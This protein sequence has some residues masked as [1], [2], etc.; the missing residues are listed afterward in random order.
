MGIRT[1]EPRICT[2]AT[3]IHRFQSGLFRRS[4]AN[5]RFILC[6]FLLICL[7]ENA[8][9]QDEPETRDELWPEVNLYVT[10]DPKWRLFFLASVYR[11]RETDVDRE[12][13]V[14]AHVDYLYKKHLVFRAGYRYGFSPTEGS[15]YQ[16]NRILFEQTVRTYIPWKV[17]LSDR[18]REELRWLSGS[19]SARYRNRLRLERDFRAG[20]H[21]LTGYGSAE[22]FYDTRFDTFNRTRFECGV[23]WTLSKHFALDIGYV[24]QNDSRSQ[25]A[26]VNAIAVDLVFTLRNR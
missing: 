7:N 21:R 11:D 6:L 9:A 10:L 24:R 8:I 17:L 18:N 25:P 2:D 3:D 26:H 15:S 14:G 5:P 13:Q 1:N 12:I 22:V 19:L 16:E 4:R 20:D 23:I